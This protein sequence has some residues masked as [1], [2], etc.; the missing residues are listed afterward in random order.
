MDDSITGNNLLHRIQICAVEHSPAVVRVRELGRTS[1]RW[2]MSTSQYI[3]MAFVHS[4]FDSAEP[5]LAVPLPVFLRVQRRTVLSLLHDMKEFSLPRG[6][7]CRTAAVWP[8]TTNHNASLP[9]LHSTSVKLK[10][11]DQRRAAGWSAWTGSRGP[12]A[13]GPA[14]A[15]SMPPSPLWGVSLLLPPSLTCS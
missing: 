15:P 3:V 9:S 10:P 7:I 14:H 6:W 4:H 1:D 5:Y 11:A 8:A 2:D 13:S 12:A